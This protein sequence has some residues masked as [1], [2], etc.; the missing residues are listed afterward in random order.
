MSSV[1]PSMEA[2]YRTWMPVDA[3][4]SDAVGVDADEEVG[5]GLVGDL[6]PLDVGDVDVLGG[7]GHDHLDARRASR[8]SRSLR[9][10]GQHQLAL[11]GAGDDAGGAAADLGLLLA[12]ARARPARERSCPW[13]DG[14]DRSPPP[15]RRPAG[16]GRGGRVA[17]VV[18]AGGGRWATGGRTSACPSWPS[19]GGRSGRAGAEWSVD[20][21]RSVVAARSRSW[22]H[23]RP[24]ARPRCSR[25]IRARLPDPSS[26]TRAIAKPATTTAPAT[27]AASRRT[28]PAAA[29]RLEA[30]DQFLGLSVP[31]WSARPSA[32]CLAASR[33]RPAGRSG[34]TASSGE[35]RI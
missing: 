8:A 18:E 6:R 19:G 11:R 27:A 15:C 26:R 34:L 13:P 32:G 17:V 31:S 4:S 33:L 10:H 23:R 3:R 16:A 24:W 35:E 29:S 20:V 14:R 5:A 28:T 9:R 21:A 25:A 12:R 30:L 22:R 1:Q 7:A 2:G